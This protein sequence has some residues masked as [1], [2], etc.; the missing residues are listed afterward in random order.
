MAYNKASE[1]K[2]WL[3][4]KE[5]EEKKMRELGVDEYLIQEL[6]EYDWKMFKEDRN[7]YRYVQEIDSSIEAQIA[8]EDQPEVRDVDG[9]L[10]EIENPELLKVLLS[11]DRLTLQIV[12]MKMEGFTTKQISASFKITEENVWQRFS[13]LRKKLEKLFK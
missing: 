8:V 6:H 1:E 2:K 11:V 4:W 5:A 12:L 9:L 10:N 13:R 7:Y 3:A